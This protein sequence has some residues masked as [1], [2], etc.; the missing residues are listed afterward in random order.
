MLCFLMISS[1]N[2][3]TPFELAQVSDSKVRIG[4]R[5]LAFRPFPIPA[6]ASALNRIC[7]EVCWWS[8][9]VN[10]GLKKIGNFVVDLEFGK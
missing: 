1:T 5:S 7:I 10:L 6:S 9:K 3:T 4:S 2:T 8:S